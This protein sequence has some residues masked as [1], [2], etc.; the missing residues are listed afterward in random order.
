MRENIIVENQVINVLQNCVFHLKHQETKNLQIHKRKTC[1]EST[2]GRH[3]G[4]SQKEGM[5][6]SS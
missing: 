1:E 5:R 2:N 6:G 3:E 4:N